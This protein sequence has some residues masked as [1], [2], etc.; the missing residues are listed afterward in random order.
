MKN[1]QT[2]KCDVKNCAYIDGNLC[3]LKSI[4]VSHSDM[5]TSFCE[6]Y[7]EK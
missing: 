7:K 1:E 3:A 6:S 2:I 4:K 5:L